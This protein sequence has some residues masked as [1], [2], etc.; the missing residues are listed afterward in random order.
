MSNKFQDDIPFQRETIEPIDKI[1]H[2]DLI[3]LVDVYRDIAVS[4]KTYMVSSESERGR[5]T[6]ISSWYI[7]REKETSKIFMLCPNYEPHH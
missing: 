7:L 4:S 3:A 5:R 1:D 6:C 2:I